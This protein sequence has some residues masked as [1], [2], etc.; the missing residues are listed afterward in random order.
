[1]TENI[2]KMNMYCSKNLEFITITLAQEIWRSYVA[3]VTLQKIHIALICLVQNLCFMTNKL[4]VWLLFTKI[5]TSL[6]ISRWRRFEMNSAILIITMVTNDS[7]IENS[8]IAKISTQF[9]TW[10]KY[11][12]GFPWRVKTWH[13]VKKIK[14]MYTFILWVLRHKSRKILPKLSWSCWLPD[15][16]E[17]GGRGD[18]LFLNMKYLWYVHNFF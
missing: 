6:P 17:G 12:F 1:M 13:P 8:A 14:K 7:S 9:W 2:S 15:W 5:V 3:C 16:L 10:K 4:V 11:N 18:H